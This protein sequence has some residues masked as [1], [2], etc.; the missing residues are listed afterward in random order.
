MRPAS[1]QDRR[2]LTVQEQN[3]VDLALE[4]FRTVPGQANEE[5][6]AWL[7]REARKLG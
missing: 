6:L 2:L 7:V 4:M 5:I 1:E 3:L